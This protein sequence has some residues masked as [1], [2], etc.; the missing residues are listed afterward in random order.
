MRPT[1]KPFP[2]LRPFPT[3]TDQ[4]ECLSVL[5]QTGKPGDIKIVS[6]N[7]S[8]Q[9][10]DTLRA[11]EKGTQVLEWCARVG[12]L[13]VAYL[14]L[15]YATAA[16]LGLPIHWPTR[17]LIA[18]AQ[19]ITLIVYLPL[20]LAYFVQRIVGP[21]VHIG[22]LAS[23]FLS[24]TF[25]LEFVFAMT[26]VHATLTMFVNLK[27]FVPAI[28][29][30]LYDAVLTQIDMALHFGVDPAIALTR[31]AAN[32]GWQPFLDL[33]YLTFFPVQVLVPLLFLL[34]ARLRP[35]RGRFFF[36]YCLLWMVGSV[37]YALWPSV[38]PI[39]HQ[40]AE[41]TTVAEAPHTQKIQAT[42]IQDYVRLRADPAYYRV[43]L[44]HGV[45][46]LP[47]LPVAMIA[48]FAL[49][50]ARVRAVS[51]ALWGLTFIT[52]IG[53]L[54]LGWHYA[55]DGYAGVVLALAVWVGARP[56]VG[57]T[58]PEDGHSATGGGRGFATERSSDANRD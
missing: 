1:G 50:T 56:L 47:S 22:G 38:G 7:G 10:V 27:Q 33:A 30:Q 54:A 57:G 21:R 43:K 2:F 13:A 39:Y 34:H 44:S 24:P 5:D 35:Q 55:V 17:H 9:T 41:F 58:R 46:A 3:M 28:N 42:L 32:A 19:M 53:S 40:P 18:Q 26:A 45:A 37:V 52:F 16:A 25:F 11:G 23:K 29:P 48:L 51:M 20:V 4:L 14:L 15:G 31:V 8:A 12:A 6:R 36:A 49:A